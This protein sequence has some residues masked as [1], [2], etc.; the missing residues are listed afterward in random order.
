MLLRRLAVVIGSILSLPAQDPPVG[1]PLESSGGR[2]IAYEPSKDRDGPQYPGLQ[3]RGDELLMTGTLSLSV[4]RLTGE[5]DPLP[6]AEFPATEEHLASDGESPVFWT[7][8]WEGEPDRPYF[9]RDWSTG[10]KVGEVALPQGL[11]PKYLDPHGMIALGALSV[12][13][14]DPSG[15]SL[16]EA[17]FAALGVIGTDFKVTACENW[18]ALSYRKNWVDR[19]A[20]L[21]RAT[22]ALA[23]DHPA[24]GDSLTMEGDLLAARVS[25]LWSEATAALYRLP[26]LSPVTSFPLDP[27]TVNGVRQLKLVDGNLWILQDQATAMG[28]VFLQFDLSE[29][30]RVRLRQRV[31]P[32]GFVLPPIGDPLAWVASGNFMGVADG[33]ATLWVWNR[34]PANDPYQPLLKIEPWEEGREGGSARARLVISDPVAWSVQVALSARSGS[35]VEGADFAP[36]SR[37]VTIPAGETQ[38]VVDVP[39]IAD[40]TLEGNEVFEV[41]TGFVS[42]AVAENASAPLVIAGNGYNLEYNSRVVAGGKLS[43]SH[44]YGSDGRVLVGLANVIRPATGVVAGLVI[45]DLESGNLIANHA[46]TPWAPNSWKCEFRDHLVIVVAY[47]YFTAYRTDTGAEVAKWPLSYDA[48][49]IGMIDADRI[50]V[51][52]SPRE[53]R[54]LRVSDGAV[55]ASV[56]FPED[57]SVALSEDKRDGSPSSILAYRT[58]RAAGERLSFNRLF[59]LDRGTLAATELHAWRSFNQSGG[60]FGKLLG[61]WQ[62]K[63]LLSV[64]RGLTAVNRD[65]GAVLWHLPSTFAIG[66]DGYRFGIVGNVMALRGLSTGE[67]D[68]TNIVRFI[69]LDLGTLI[70]RITPQELDPVGQVWSGFISAYEDGW[71]LGHRSASFRVVKTPVRPNVSIVAPA[72]QENAATVLSAKP[73]EGF[74]GSHPIR[75]SEFV[76]LAVERNPPAALLSGLPIDLQVDADGVDFTVAATRSVNGSEKTWLRAT[77]PGNGRILVSGIQLVVVESHVVTV[78][79]GSFTTGGPVRGSRGR[80]VAVTELLL[81]VGFPLEPLPGGARAGVVDLYNRQTGEFLRSIEAPAGTEGKRFGH[82]VAMSGSKL[83]VGAPG[84]QSMGRV[85]VYDALSGSLIREL[86]QK[87]KAG[88]FGQDIKANDR[89]IAVSAT[90]PSRPVSYE[91]LEKEAGTVMVFDATTLKPGFTRTTKGE[92]LGASIALTGDRIYIAAPGA[93]HQ[94]LYNSGMIR[95]YT[96]PKG[97]VVGTIMAPEPESLGYFTSPIAASDEVVFASAWQGDP[98][99]TS[100][101]QVHGAS[102]LGF[103]GFHAMPGDDLSMQRILAHDGW[104]IGGDDILRFYRPGNLRPVASRRIVDPGGDPV[105]YP[106]PYF[107]R[108][109]IAAVGNFLYWADYKPKV[110]PMPAVP[111]VAGLRS[112]S[113]ADAN[114]DGRGDEF[115]QLY[116]HRGGASLPARATLAESGQNGLRFLLQADSDIPFGMDLW[117]EVSGDLLRWEPLLQWRWESPGWRDADGNPLEVSPDGGIETEHRADKSRVFFRTRAASR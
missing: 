47:G 113:A 50:L 84:E 77:A 17:T 10:R 35:A 2:W 5:V 75:I 16:R 37:T 6:R 85:F 107:Y 70:D 102:D 83:I 26:G 54:I 61:V 76:D 115:D 97:K 105:V 27:P 9:L 38:A 87:G 65:T 20:I 22:L 42:G 98:E 82:A 51:R 40:T 55:L 44:I 41:V 7:R 19:V 71:V 15:G 12:L 4:H 39:L 114:G 23:G 78:P 56:A 103:L 92:F 88:Q 64:E 46:G 28:C 91:A 48:G 60:D 69:D 59:E 31:S 14:T 53:L 108:S 99:E 106:G 8:P 62:N 13:A 109:N 24:V 3:K 110:M 68:S 11:Y 96:L 74:I 112:A 100:A 32:P 45:A 72:I 34:D 33:A 86:K 67:P 73:K 111:T 116:L 66:S 29:L 81:A 25:S 89:W 52:P 43:W 101:L 18:I 21:N 36:W 90:G 63:L 30:P 49:V 93:N 58:G 94:K 57:S 79:D 1:F 80:S 117:F 95:A 104:M